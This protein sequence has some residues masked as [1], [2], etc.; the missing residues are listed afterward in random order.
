MKRD[1][2][3]VAGLV[4]QSGGTEAADLYVDSSGFASVL[5][6]KA[7]GEPF[8][9]FRSSLFCDRAVVGGWQRPPGDP[10]RPYT[11][12][13]TM[14]S[15]WAWQIEHERRVNRGY[16]YC[17]DFVADAQAE[18]EFRSRNPDVGPTRVVKFVSGCYRRHWVQNVVAVG[19]AGG[20]VE[21][22]EATALGVAAIQ[23]WGLADTLR[24]PGRRPTPTQVEGY[25]AY[26]RRNWAAIRSFIAIHYK[27]NTRL[28]TPFWRECRE[29][30]D[31]AGAE[32]V[33]Q[34]YRENGPGGLWRDTFLDPLDQFGVGGYYALLLGM[35]VPHDRPH[36]PTET[37]LKAWDA[38]RRRHQEAARYGMTVA[39]ALDV[40]RSPQWR[41]TA[42]DAGAPA[43]LE[44]NAG[45][46][47]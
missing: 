8:E 22:L 32:P 46:G 26:H 5:L 28:D 18:E 39:E 29:K 21:P 2:H 27:F 20:F 38:R 31:L 40:V 17:S 43:G 45:Q 15:G 44:G 23:S 6:G 36:A 34:Y 7:L 13:E 1:E 24:E 9:S 37:E 33:V 10:V 4:L 47:A 16:V 12:C 30:T 19:N 11:T 35:R 25:N 41:W 3:G 42:P 14:P